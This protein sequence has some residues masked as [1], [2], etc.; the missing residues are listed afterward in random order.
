MRNRNIEISV[1]ESVKK[2]IHVL[3]VNTQN[4]NISFEI[5]MSKN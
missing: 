4:L 2:I 1:S 3:T 5:S